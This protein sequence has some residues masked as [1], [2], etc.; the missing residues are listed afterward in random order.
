MLST[1]LVA[2][3]LLATALAAPASAVATPE[4]PAIDAGARE[5][6]VDLRQH[7]ARQQLPALG[8]DAVL[9]VEGGQAST[10]SSAR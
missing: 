3:A 6:G 7:L 10:G 9:P 5:A 1:L 2:L 8:D 4:T